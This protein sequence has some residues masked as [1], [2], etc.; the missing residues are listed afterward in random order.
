LPAIFRDRFNTAG[1]RRTET[2]PWDN[3]NNLWSSIR[4][5]DRTERFDDSNFN[6]YSSDLRNSMLGTALWDCYIGMGGDSPYLSIRNKAADNIIRIM[7]EMLLITPDDTTTGVAHARRMAQDCIQADTALSGGLYSKVMDNA[8]IAR[9]LWN[10]RPVDLYI[11]DSS[12]DTGVIPSPQ[13]HWESP[14]IWVRNNLT[15]DNPD[16]GHERPICNQPNY[17]YVRVHN[18]GTQAATANTFTVEAF[19]CDPGTGMIWPDH[20]TTMGNMTITQ[21]IPAGGSLRIGPFTWTPVVEN[22]ECLLAVVHGAAD[23]AIPATLIG[24]VPHGE[25]VRFDNNV[26]QRNVSPLPSVPG[27]KT[28]TSFMLRGGIQPTM[29]K[30]MLDSLAMPDDTKIMVR[31]LSRIVRNA[32]LS[33]L[34]IKTQSNTWTTLEMSGGVVAE[35]AGF[36]LR[37]N[38]Q[39]NVDLT[40]DFSLQAEHLARYPLIA[41]QEQDEALAG[42]MTIEIIAVKEDEDWVFGNPRSHELHITSCPYWTRISQKNKQPFETVDAGIA[43]GYNGCAFCLPEFD[44]D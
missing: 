35:V 30:L 15:G 16:A 4:R 42:R 21:Q 28:K 39:V 14:D 37:A 10:L 40:I 13:L 5:L 25:L 29:N 9:G 43:R 17:M 27:G 26:G 7:M 2:F 44:T 33:H 6:T 1:N 36:E 22:H 18:R 41:T 24:S 23:P 19:H 34:T 31:V 32:E 38:D 11:R 12:A 8:F 20:F 3:V